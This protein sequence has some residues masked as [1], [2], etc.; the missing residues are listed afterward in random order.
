[1]NTLKNN[2]RLIGN[3]GTDPE[4]KTYDSGKVRAKLSLATSE[5]YKNAEGERVQETQWHNLIAWGPAARIAEQYLKKGNE[6]AVQGRLIYRSY[7]DQEGLRK[8][9]TEVVVSELHMLSRQAQN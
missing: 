9:I 8:Y 5:Y 1:M 6:I 7:E 3:L 2:V 4:V